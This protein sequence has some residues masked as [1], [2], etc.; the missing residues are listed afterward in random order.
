MRFSSGY[1]EAFLG[2]VM[3][4]YTHYILIHS[5][6]IQV[7]GMH[8]LL[9]KSNLMGLE[10][11]EINIYWMGGLLMKQKMVGWIFNEIQTYRMDCFNTP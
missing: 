11:Y 4:P 6:T 3:K 7:F 5:I 9:M 8:A 1:Y 2:H 10:Y